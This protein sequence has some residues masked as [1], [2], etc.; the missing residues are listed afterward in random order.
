M[1]ILETENVATLRAEINF[2]LEIAGYGGFRQEKEEVV[3]FLKKM[4]QKSV[5][6]REFYIQF[7]IQ[8]TEIIYGY[9]RNNEGVVVDSEPSI[10]LFSDK[11][12]IYAASITDADW[13][14][15]VEQVAFQLAEEFQQYRVYVTYSLVDVKIFRKQ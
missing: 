4:I 5:S 2:E 15:V 11:N 7:C 3:S 1:Y 14:C 6:K 12:P 13:K 9:K 10:T 8:A